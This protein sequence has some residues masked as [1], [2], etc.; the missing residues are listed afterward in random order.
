MWVLILSYFLWWAP[1]PTNSDYLILI[2]DDCSK[3]SKY[4]FNQEEVQFGL[5]K[6]ILDYNFLG[7]THSWLF[8]KDK[9]SVINMTYSEILKMNPKYSSELTPK[10]WDHMAHGKDKKKIYILIP[11]DY[12]SER[13]FVFKHKFVLYEVRIGLSGNE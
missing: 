11:E 8:A 10:D 9:L 12:C 7:L 2:A 4:D 13:R 1:I 6:D 3:W 5:S